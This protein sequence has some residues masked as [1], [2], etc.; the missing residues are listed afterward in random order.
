M[1]RTDLA[2]LTYLDR[3][4]GSRRVERWLRNTRGIDELID[5]FLAGEYPANAAVVAL[6]MV[7]KGLDVTFAQTASTAADE[8]AAQA[9]VEE[10]LEVIRLAAASGLRDFDVSLGLP[11]LGLSLGADG[12]AL[13]LGHARVVAAAAEAAGATV[14]IDAGRVNTVDDVLA[15]VLDLRRDHPSVGVT[16]QSKLRRSATD[17]RDFTYQ[18]SRVRLCKGAFPAGESDAYQSRIETDRSFVRLLRTLMQSPAY[19][20]TATHDSRMVSINH[21][22]V[23]RNGR[24]RDDYEFQMIM[25]VRSLEH[26]RLVDTGRRLR[27]YLPYGRDWCPYLVHRLTDDPGMLSLLGRQLVSRR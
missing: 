9:S 13:A 11:A 10:H 23:R 22:L 20:M 2:H 12:P 8:Q 26:R 19:P 4:A 17:L 16:L 14:T 15:T 7:T 6:D 25:G 3:L 24:T 18:G 21:E 1:S 27:V 5:R